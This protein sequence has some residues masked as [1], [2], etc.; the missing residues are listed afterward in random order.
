MESESL[1]ALNRNQWPFWIGINGRFASECAALAH[2]PERY[3][4]VPHEQ[5]F[6]P[7]IYRRVAC[8][9]NF[10]IHPAYRVQPYSADRDIDA[11]SAEIVARTVPAD[12]RYIM[13][14]TRA[15]YA[16]ELAIGAR[17]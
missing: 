9:V 13:L 14:S 2:A 17:G 3:L 8:V 10:A 11:Q 1:A 7:S 12:V 16:P 6:D 5:A 15:V 4:T